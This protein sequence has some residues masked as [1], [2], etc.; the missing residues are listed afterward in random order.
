VEEERARN[1]TIVEAHA[2]WEARILVRRTGR[3]VSLPPRGHV[4]FKDPGP[5]GSPKQQKVVVTEAEKR[6]TLQSYN[7]PVDSPGFTKAMS[8]SMND[9][10]AM[11]TDKEYGM[12]WS[13]TDFGSV[14]DHAGGDYKEED[15]D[16]S[17]HDCGEGGDSELDWSAY[18]RRF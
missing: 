5:G 17:D 14:I 7:D 10:R 12:W 8:E 9:H 2:L 13:A 4:S 6:A 18:D 3:E 11:A 1:I 15:W 16:L